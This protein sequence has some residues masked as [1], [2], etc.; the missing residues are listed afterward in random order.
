MGLEDSWVTEY[1]VA[2]DTP[3]TWELEPLGAGTL[4]RRGVIKHRR[5]ACS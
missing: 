5:G 3:D 4:G 2:V 1:R